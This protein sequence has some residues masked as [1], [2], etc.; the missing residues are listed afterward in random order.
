[1]SKTEYEYRFTGYKK[2]DI[3]KKIEN[4]GGYRVHPLGHITNEQTVW[5]SK[6]EGEVDKKNDFANNQRISEDTIEK[7]YHENIKATYTITSSSSKAP[8]NP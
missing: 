3:I 4:L 7:V 8:G 1:M 5:I 2:K 6:T